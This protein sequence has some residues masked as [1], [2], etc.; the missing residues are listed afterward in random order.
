MVSWCITWAWEEN[1]QTLEYDKGE[2]QS[3]CEMF[4]D[5]QL[6]VSY[7]FGIVEVGQYVDVLGGEM[8]ILLYT[9]TLT[10]FMLF[11]QLKAGG[12]LC[13]QRFDKYHTNDVMCRRVQAK[14]K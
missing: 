1:K 11:P 4:S 10:A 5:L 12:P 3:F 14:P 9:R 8:E 2:D 13:T 6:R 7:C